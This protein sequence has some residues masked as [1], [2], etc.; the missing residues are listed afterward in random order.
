LLS[1]DRD[2][3]RNGRRACRRQTRMRNVKMVVIGGSAHAGA[4][5]QKVHVSPALF[6]PTA[7]DDVAAA[8]A[9]AATGSPANGRFEIAGRERVRLDELVRR[10]LV[11]SG[12]QREVVADLKAR[13]LGVRLDYRSLV[14][15]GDARTG[16]TRFDDWLS[17]PARQG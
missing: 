11:T 15:G 5:G 2:R 17:R 8:M 10:F 16:P 1:N 3:Q 12:N 7:S 6:Q 4:V 14:P 9:D 13:Y